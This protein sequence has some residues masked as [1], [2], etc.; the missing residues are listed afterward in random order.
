[1]DWL[2]SRSEK[3]MVQYYVQASTC[4]KVIPHGTLRITFILR[5]HQGV[6]LLCCHERAIWQ[7][8]MVLGVFSRVNGFWSAVEGS[9]SGRLCNFMGRLRA[10]FFGKLYGICIMNVSILYVI[11]SVGLVGWKLEVNLVYI[12]LTTSVVSCAHSSVIVFVDSTYKTGKMRRYHS[13]SATEGIK[14]DEEAGATTLSH[15]HTPI[16]RTYRLCLFS[17]LVCK[18]A[19][20]V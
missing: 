8:C 3:K 17:W 18:H 9:W 19:M 15:H 14:V 2:L 12:E 10:E 6:D 4:L 5:P 16:V 11:W 7:K 13:R 20:C 1:M